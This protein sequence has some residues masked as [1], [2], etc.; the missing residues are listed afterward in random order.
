MY[1]TKTIKQFLDGIAEIDQSQKQ[2]IIDR[3]KTLAV[4]NGLISG[5]DVDEIFQDRR[6]CRELEEA[7]ENGELVESV[8]VLF[9]D[10]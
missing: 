8:F 3:T 6:L 9:E 2:K 1:H 7:W 10:H 5:G 4:P